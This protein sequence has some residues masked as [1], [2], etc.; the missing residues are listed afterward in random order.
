MLLIEI[1]ENESDDVISPNYNA[2][3]CISPQFSIL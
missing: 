3:Q 1:A 2:V